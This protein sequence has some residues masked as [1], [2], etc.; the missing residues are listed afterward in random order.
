MYT[1][2][3]HN[4]KL[5]STFE[6]KMTSVI[7]KNLLTLSFALLV[8]KF[9][10][11]QDTF[12]I[13]AVDTVTGELG[14]A[15]AS[16]IGAPQIPQGCYILSDVIPDVGV[17]HT[18]AYY[19]A[20]NQN[21]AHALMLQGIPPQE[22]IALLVAN[23][24]G[25]NPTIRQYGIVDIYTGVPRTA[26]YTGE[27]CDDYKDHIIGPNYIIQGN[28]LLGQQIL[29]SMEARFLATEGELACKLMA[30]LQGAKVVGADTRCTNA[31]VSSLSGFLR[32]AKPGDEIND[33]YLD[34]NVPS[35]LNGID[36]ID[37]LQVL[38]D[39]WGGCEVTS[40]S[41]LK[42]QDN[43]K[44]YPNPAGDILNI[45][46]PK[47]S[48]ATI[49]QIY[50]MGGDKLIERQVK[51]GTS[52]RMKHLLSPGVYICRIIESDGRHRTLK[53]VIM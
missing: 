42:Q 44:I 31:G 49:I 1:T 16:C 20:G 18:Q 27:N 19:T 14:S 9:C 12:S 7:M 26:A 23:D 22:I 51:T 4:I 45:E 37:S 28:I 11:G 53:F 17:I 5:M 52:V 10:I 50:S 29:D 39:Q 43:V 30:A 24:V 48:E 21:Y 47:N 40:V 35:T 2:R 46:L 3:R 33:L 38:I 41:S 32:V 13:V 8:L 15:G 25:S 34:L 36:P 6:G